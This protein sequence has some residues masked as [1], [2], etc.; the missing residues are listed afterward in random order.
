MQRAPLLLKISLDDVQTKEE[1]NKLSYAA[2]TWDGLDPKG[3]VL[4]AFMHS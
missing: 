4:D 2:W 1:W 3:G